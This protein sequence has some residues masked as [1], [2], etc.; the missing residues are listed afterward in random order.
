MDSLQAPMSSNASP[1]VLAVRL[2]LL[3]GIAGFVHAQAENLNGCQW[4]EQVS[5]DEVLGLGVLGSEFPADL[6]AIGWIQDQDA[7]IGAL[8]RPPV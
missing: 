1:R 5:W 7:T 6:D 2:F 4:D 8:D 3:A